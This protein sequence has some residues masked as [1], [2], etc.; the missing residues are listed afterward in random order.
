MKIT[1]YLHSCLLI[2]EAGKTILIDPGE[3]TYDAYVFPLE[4]LPALDNIII[5]HEHADHCS[6][7]FLKKLLARFPKTPITTN[8]A[9]KVLLEKENIPGRTSLPSYVYAKKIPH[10]KVIG[11]TPP[12][13]TCFTLFN[14]LT[15]PGDSFHISEIAEILALPV[16]APWGSMTQAVNLAVSL[17]PQVVIPIHDWHWKDEARKGF[18]SRLEEYFKNYNIQFLKPETGETLAVV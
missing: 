7:P 8:K 14:R 13:N 12:E 11:V 3:Y 18:Y 1:K 4:T 9:V 6:I 10:E 16:Q 17:K 5:T 15:H 2:E